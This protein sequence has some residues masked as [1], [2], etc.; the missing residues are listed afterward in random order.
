M[1]INWKVRIRHRQFWVA[2]ISAFVLLANQVASI[3]DVDITLMSAKIQ[4]SLESILLI[5]ALFGI[6]I[7]PTTE[8]VKDSSQAMVYVKP[9]CDTDDVPKSIEKVEEKQQE[10]KIEVQHET[11]IEVIQQQQDASKEKIE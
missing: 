1:K 9:R 10:M 4:Q 7:D 8:G 3:F 11:K 5:L 6:I 2:I